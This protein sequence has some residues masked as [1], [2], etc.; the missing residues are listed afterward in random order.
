MF[1][2]I[3]EIAIEYKTGAR[4]LRGIFEELIAPILFVVPDNPAIR[5]VGIASLFTDPVYVMADE[6]RPRASHAAA[7]GLRREF[8]RTTMAAAFGPWNPGLQSQIPRALAHLRDDL[9][10]RKTS[11]RRS[12]EA[13]ELADLTGLDPVELVVFR[14]ERL[15]L[16][17]VLVRVMADFSVPDGAKIEDLGIN[18]RAIVRTILDAATSSRGW[19]RSPPPTTKRS[20]RIAAR[21]D[22]ELAALMPRSGRR[23]RRQRS[24]R[25]LAALF[26]P[27]GAGASRPTP[28]R[29]GIRASSPDGRSARGRAA[30]TSSAPPA[31]RSRASSR[32]AVEPP[33]AAMGHARDDRAARD[34]PRVQRRRRPTGSARRSSRC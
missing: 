33:R 30:T 24:A 6:A 15:A 7:A 9:P 27:P 12:T 23:R 10:A 34:G 3:S 31:A 19:R 13:R 1:E 20:R 5:K 14:P 26:R 32:R 22:A 18:F 8:R 2:Q 17:E 29:A 21:V 4:S 11:S 16:H 25:W 28:H